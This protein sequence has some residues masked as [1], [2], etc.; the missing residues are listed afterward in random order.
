MLSN[1]SEV[2][3]EHGLPIVRHFRKRNGFEG[4][5]DSIEKRQKID[6]W[7]AEHSQLRRFIENARNPIKEIVFIE[8]WIMPHLH[9][10][11]YPTT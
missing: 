10:H 6:R 3:D 8:R 1:H 5:G 4:L 9:L 7:D 11:N 2:R